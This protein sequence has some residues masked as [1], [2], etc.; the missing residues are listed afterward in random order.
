MQKYSW[1]ELHHTYLHCMYHVSKNADGN[2][3][4]IVLQKY[5]KELK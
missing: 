5:Q 3:H 1:L 2:H 4:G